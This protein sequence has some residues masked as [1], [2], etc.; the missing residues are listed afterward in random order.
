MIRLQPL[1]STVDSYEL[2][3]D[4]ARTGNALSLEA[5]KQFGAATKTLTAEEARIVVIR[6]ANNNFCTGGDVREF[7]TAGNLQR[8]VADLV[9]I[10]HA[11]LLRLMRLDAI[12]IAAV[13][14][15]A[16]GAGMSL[17]CA[18]D[19]VLAREDSR[20]VTAYIQL[21]L[22]PDGGLTF[23][24]PSRIG[25]PKALQLT[26][27]NRQLNAEEALQWGLVDQVLSSEDFEQKTRRL[28]KYLTRASLASIQTKKLIRLG[29]IHNLER[30]LQAEAQAIVK[31]A[32]LPESQEQARAFASGQIGN[33]F[34]DS[35][36]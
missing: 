20:F 35:S 1:P 28:A 33:A 34:E 12:L 23:T 3:I 2:W 31:L 17:M 29:S 30:H 7:A 24:L 18:C 16:A 26:L 32:G 25:I 36:S 8:Y 6:G 9:D 4:N 14:G 13:Q 27:T 5:A 11:G 21:L 10:F 22:S 19:L 15:A